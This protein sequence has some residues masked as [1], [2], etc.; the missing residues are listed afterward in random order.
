MQE[1]PIISEKYVS[2]MFN[3]KIQKN[4]ESRRNQFE[5]GK[6]NLGFWYI[7]S[8]VFRKFFEIMTPKKGF[9]KHFLTIEHLFKSCEKLVEQTTPTASI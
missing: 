2:F 8:G 4:I 1:K 6:K 5:N 3:G 9:G 7:T